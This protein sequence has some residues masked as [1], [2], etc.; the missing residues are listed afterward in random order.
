VSQPPPDP[1]LTG[2]LPDDVPT[3]QQMVR[4]LRALVREQQAL[5]A[6]IPQL[7]ATVA[8][9]QEQVRELAERTN[10]NSGNSSQP[11]SSDPP[12]RQRPQKPAS[13]KKRGGQPGHPGK[14]RR[15]EPPGAVDHVVVCA[16]AACAQCG[17]RFPEDPPRRRKVRRFQ[18]VELPPIRPEI[19]E[20]QVEARRCPCC[21][22]RTWGHLPAGVTRCVGPRVQAVAALL[23]GA[24]RLPRR[25]VQALLTDLL[26]VQLSL[27]TLSA[28]EADTTRALAAPY[29]ELASE[30]PRAPVV[31]VD[32]TSWKEAG[33]LHWIWTAV[34]RQ[35]AFFHVD[36]HRS[37]AVFDALVPETGA[38]ATGPVIISDR[39]SAYG[40][41]P[42]ARRSLCWAHL[43]RD[44]RAAEERGGLDAVVGRWVLEVFGKVLE[45][46]HRYRNGALAREAFLTEITRRQE[47]LRAP[48]RWGAEHGSRKTQALCRDL[49]EH[50]PSLWTWLEVEGG[51]PTNNA[52]ER[53][54]RPAVLWRKGSF[55]HQSA[56]G[57][58]FVE[59]MLT[60]VTTLRLQ[61]RN[62]WRYL[63]DTCEAGRLGKS[64]P[65]L[66]PQAP[67]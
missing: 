17:A 51:E 5:L 56:T 49:L 6:V 63:L 23:S 52:A 16:P 31:G 42:P 11:P 33:A 18:V 53:A 50:W 26:G 54:L 14:F 12:W 4:D 47:E 41:L 65:S 48:L 58:Q 66:L 21:G 40:H 34:T 29:M 46:W 9:L 22:R 67:A 20:Y 25:Q 60:A 10:R 30:V 2:E 61:G 7:Q 37:R 38:P 62:V 55:G 8:Q 57:E 28:L 27:G 64:A 24:C 45:P 39:Y 59:R 19:T 3:L 32:E 36:R 15:L 13:G 44:F 43:A 35:F 1:L